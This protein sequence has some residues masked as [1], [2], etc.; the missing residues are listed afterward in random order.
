MIERETC[1]CDRHDGGV[2]AAEFQKLIDRRGI[3][4]NFV[5]GAL[6]HLQIS[7]A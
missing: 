3:V 1:F 6:A 4:L 2:T 7:R 5:T